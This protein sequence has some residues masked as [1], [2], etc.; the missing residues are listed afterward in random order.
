MKIHFLKTRWSDMIVLESNGKFALIDTG[1][2]EQYEQLSKYLKGLG[3]NKI[4]FILLTH[5]HRDHYG[6]VV[7]LVKNFD[8]CKVYFKEYGLHDAYTSAGQPAD[9]DYR[10]SEKEK[11]LAMRDAIRTY[12]ECV[13]VEGLSNIEFDG[14]TLDLYGTA[15]TIQAIYDDEAYPETYHK[16]AFSENQN[17]M[18]IF[19]EADGRTVFLAGD[20]MDIK[21]SHPL[22]DY[23]HTQI[24]RK[25][26]REID[27]YKAAHHGTID[28]ASMEVLNIYKPKLAVITNAMEYLVNYDSIDNLK[29][30][31]PSVEIFIT[32][33]GN[34]VVDLADLKVMRNQN[35][36]YAFFEILNS[37]T[38]KNVCN[39]LK[40]SCE[41]K[42]KLLGPLQRTGIW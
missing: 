42:S 6:N 23:V 12:S 22:A 13:M 5:F 20:L 4:D 25:I 29:K 36:R 2:D 30:A 10:N 38:K 18:G 24:A 34:V 37:L 32:D 1:F 8:V 40:Q 19:F 17:S 35:D 39:N 26:S 31:N 7:D 14:H 33:E 41:K 3:A 9:D 28:T 27:V 21:S 15:N 16:N 11:W